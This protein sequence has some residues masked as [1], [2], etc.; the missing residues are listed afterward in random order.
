MLKPLANE[1]ASCRCS[2][3]QDRYRSYRT[4]TLSAA[5]PDVPL[6]GDEGI[7]GGH[8]RETQEIA[9]GSGQDA[10]ESGGRRSVQHDLDR[11]AVRI[12][13]LSN[14]ARRALHVAEIADFIQPFAADLEAV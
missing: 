13:R 9:V 10:L 4:P 11:R 5:P 3:I 12:D 14:V 6:I 8:L 2:G 1:Y 7:V